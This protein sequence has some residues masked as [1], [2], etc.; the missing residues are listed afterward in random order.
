MQSLDLSMGVMHFRTVST[1]A[2]TFTLGSIELSTKREPYL[3]NEIEI[4]EGFSGGEVG[5][6][7]VCTSMYSMI[8]RCPDTPADR[9]LFFFFL[10][11]ACA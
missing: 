7:V 3:S 5:Y 4:M 8:L 10:R 11:C 9:C 1:L 2:W 6:R